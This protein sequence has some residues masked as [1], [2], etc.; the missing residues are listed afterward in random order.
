MR[1]FEAVAYAVA[2]NLKGA[3]FRYCRLPV[4]TLLLASGEALRLF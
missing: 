1:G 3:I 2:R 4:L